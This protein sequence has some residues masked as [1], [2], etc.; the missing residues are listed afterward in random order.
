MKIFVDADA[1]PKAAKEILY[2]TSKRLNVELI[3]VANTYTRVPTS[4]F[5]QFVLVPNNPDEADDRIID[6]MHSG[7]LVISSDIPLAD[8][9]IKKGGVVLDPRGILL[10]ADNIGEK[11]TMRNFKEELRQTGI[12]T[13]GPN[14]Y[15][16]QEKQRFANQL[17]RYLTLLL[18]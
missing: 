2:R 11:L 3:L 13:R 4:E 7:D 9:V 14:A 17:D 15:G 10:T 12:D 8:R 18:K 16:A 6:L 5:I 1:C